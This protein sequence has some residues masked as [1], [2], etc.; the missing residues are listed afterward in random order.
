[1]TK[2]KW[3]HLPNAKYINWVIASSKEHPEN[4]V[5]AI[6][7]TGD[8]VQYHRSRSNT[9]GLIKDQVSWYEARSGLLATN[10]EVW[11]PTTGAVIALIAYDDCGYMI[12]SDVDELKLIAAFG[13]ERAIMLLPACIIY[14]ETKELTNLITHV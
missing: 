10:D 12:E 6:N 5:G 11:I 9:Y 8:K 13:A 3:S 1:M 14:N 2:T 4:W 7:S